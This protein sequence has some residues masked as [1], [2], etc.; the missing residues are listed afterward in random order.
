MRR[1]FARQLAKFCGARLS[2]G[3]PPLVVYTHHITRTQFSR[4]FAT[5]SVWLPPFQTKGAPKPPTLIK[6]GFAFAFLL[7]APF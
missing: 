2:L 1:M 6:G 4:L 3:L 7:C 5:E